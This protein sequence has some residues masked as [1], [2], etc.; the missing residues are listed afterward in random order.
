[1]I[2]T[3]KSASWAALTS[4][5]ACGLIL[6]TRRWHDGF[7]LDGNHGV[8]KVH[9]TAVPRIGGLGVMIGLFTG[10]WAH[11]DSTDFIAADH[12]LG[13]TLLASIPAFAAGLAEDVTKR[14]S[15]RSRLLATMA[16]GFVAFWFTGYCISRVDVW[17]LDSILAWA[18]ICILF[19]AFAVA[20]VANAYNI[21]DGFNGLSSAAMIVAVASMCAIAYDVGDAELVQIGLVYVAAVLGFMAW[22]YPFGRIFLGDG[23][24]YAMGFLIAWMAVMLPARHP[25]VSPWASLMACGYPVMETIYTILRRAVAS[26]NSGAPDFL[27]LHSLLKKVV[28]RQKFKRFHSLIRNAMVAVTLMPFVSAIA[29]TGIFFYRETEFLIIAFGFYFTIYILTHRVLFKSK[30]AHDAINR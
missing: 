28:I 26:Q 25:D 15:V 18:P 3:L 5:V 4:F 19:T 17:G 8:Q 12:M 29:I 23:G 14:V 22:N 13:L 1:M 30:F 11:E 20:G 16:S 7:T 10:W 9:N 2:I 6:L 24:A 21:I 27:H